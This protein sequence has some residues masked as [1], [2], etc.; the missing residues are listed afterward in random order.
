MFGRPYNS[1][2]RH[3]IYRALPHREGGGVPR[4]IATG[5]FDRAAVRAQLRK[6]LRCIRNLDM[7]S[8]LARHVIRVRSQ[9][10]SDDASIPACILARAGARSHV[11]P[12]AARTVASLLH[13][14]RAE[15]TS[16]RKSKEKTAK[17]R[18]NR[19][20][21]L[22]SF[23]EHPSLP[24]RLNTSPGRL[25]TGEDYG[26]SDI[27]HTLICCRQRSR[28]LVSCGSRRPLDATGHV[29]GAA[30][31]AKSSTPRMMSTNS[32]PP[33]AAPGDCSPP[34]SASIAWSD[35]ETRGRNARRL[36]R[37]STPPERRS[38]LTSWTAA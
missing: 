28:R 12:T 5:H 18:T 32:F 14:H 29:R 2:I 23:P 30:S 13:P 17:E 22:L 8:L 37:K 24:I 31:P 38:E 27:R 33:L 26:A 15:A 9:K 21:E 7:F 4:D 19:Q 6:E 10:A 34:T 25:H 11:T 1:L 3:Q 16:K 20:A 35:R 36:A